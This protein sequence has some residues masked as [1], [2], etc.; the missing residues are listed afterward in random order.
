MPHHSQT[1]VVR[2]VGE[3]RFTGSAGTYKKTLQMEGPFPIERKEFSQ[4]SGCNPI[5]LL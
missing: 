2:F 3:K 5:D 4:F 1:K